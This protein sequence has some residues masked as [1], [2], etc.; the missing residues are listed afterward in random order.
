MIQYGSTQW[1]PNRN[2]PVAANEDETREVRCCSDTAIDGLNS[3][4]LLK[5]IAPSHVIM[6]G[7]TIASGGSLPLMAADTEE[8]EVR[9]CSDTA[10]DDWIQWGSCS[11]WGA[12][13]LPDCI[14]AATF[15]EAVDHCTAQDAR[16]CTPQELAD[17]CTRGSGCNHDQ[18]QIWTSELASTG[19]D[20]W[21]ESEI[22]TCEDAPT[23]S[24]AVSQCAA[25][26]ARLCTA[27]E[28]L[29]DCTR[30]SGCSHDE[31]QC[32]SSTPAN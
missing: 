22:P 27:E 20:V 19:C 23:Y 30:Y 4:G 17:D 2:A 5:K 8:H 24:E 7:S 16:L 28:L 15:A 3:Q 29:N 31:D 12:S 9:C 32:W 25:F 14:D 10:K 11:V 26:G 13:E 6:W 18:D 21:A 1:N